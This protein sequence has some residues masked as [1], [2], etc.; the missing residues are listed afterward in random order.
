MESTVL[1]TTFDPAQPL[2]DDMQ[3]QSLP[4]YQADKPQW[5]YRKVPK[6]SSFRSFDR[7]P[8]GVGRRSHLHITYVLRIAL[9]LCLCLSFQKVIFRYWIR[10]APFLLIPLRRIDIV[11]CVLSEG[12][13]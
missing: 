6:V 8:L 3:V 1:V 12:V 7:I 10:R 13:H 11:S 9:R 2:E 4:V 5:T